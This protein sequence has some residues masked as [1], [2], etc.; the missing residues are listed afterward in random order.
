MIY[1]GAFLRL[2]TNLRGSEGGDG[3]ALSLQDVL[4]GRVRA[5]TTSL[6]AVP[7]DPAANLANA[8]DNPG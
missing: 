1:D 4:V 5:P 3:R 7:S 8:S 6:G 2:T